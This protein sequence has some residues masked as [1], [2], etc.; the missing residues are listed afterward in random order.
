VKCWHEKILTLVAKRVL[1]ISRW[2]YE[3]EDKLKST[4]E[5]SLHYVIIDMSG[6][7]S[8]TNMCLKLIIIDKLKF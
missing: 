8:I 1:R 6:K 2:I 5:A 4:G 3:E 7:Q